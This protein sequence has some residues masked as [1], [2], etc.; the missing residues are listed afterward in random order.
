MKR[1]ALICAAILLNSVS[2]MAQARPLP[3]SAIVP[4]EKHLSNI[5]QLTFEGENAEAYLSFD[6]K[7]LIFQSH[8]NENDCDQIYSIN[9]DGSERNLISTGK[10]RTTCSYFMPDGKHILY[11]STHEAAAECPP[12]A[13][14][15][16]GYVWMLYPSFDIF[17]ATA[18]GKELKPLI[19]RPGYDAEATVSPKGDRIVF[20][21]THSGDIDL[22]TCNLEGGDI[23]QITNLPGYDGGAF[24]SFDGTKI[25]YRA[26]RPQG[27]ELE[28]YRELL[29]KNMIKPRNLEIYTANADGSN[30]VQL[31]NNGKA[32]F[33][34][35]F[36]PDG[37]RVIFSSN[38]GDPKGRNFDLYMINTDGSGLERITHFDGFDGFPMFTRD[39]K[40]LVFCSNRNNAKPGDTNI[41]IADWKD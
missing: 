31:T 41:F 26:S 21:S 34:P 11:A 39:G 33:A 16:N 1:I 38:I 2:V 37:K 6:E 32:N 4:Q 35:F 23:R 29:A 22:Y 28:E 3:E 8:N 14:M 15:S 25:V 13:D 12:P 10:G 40:T 19:K 9:L 18:D 36:H 24:F 7:R 30:P 27:K 17:T 5:R 20:T